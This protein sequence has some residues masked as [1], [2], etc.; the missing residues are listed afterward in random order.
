MKNVGAYATNVQANEI[1]N[2]HSDHSVDT[3]VKFQYQKVLKYKFHC[4]FFEI[5]IA[6]YRRDFRYLGLDLYYSTRPTRYYSK[7]RYLLHNYVD[8]IPI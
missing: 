8:T 5:I 3:F 4:Q 7:C 2:I 6:S 1:L